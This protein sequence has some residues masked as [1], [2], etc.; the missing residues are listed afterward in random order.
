MSVKGLNRTVRAATKIAAVISIMLAPT[1]P[2]QAAGDLLVAPTRIVLDGRRGTEVILNNIGSEVATYRISLELRRMNA[3]GALDEVTV[4]EANILEKAALEMIRF[5]PRRVTLPPNQPQ[6]IRIGVTPNNTLPDGEYR[7]HMLFR[8]IPVVPAVTQDK[9]PDSVQIQ[10]I[11]IYGVTIPIIV[12]KGKLQAVAALA[13]PRLAKVE[14]GQ[15]LDFE[16]SRKGDRSV[17]GD[18]RVSKPGVATPIVVAKG[19]AIYPERDTRTVS[20]FIDETAAPQ[21]KGP[22][23]IGYYETQDAGGALIAEVKTVLN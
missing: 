5:A 2:V 18:I 16:M 17:Y 21:M 1:G 19:I 6:S 9:A 7:A 23:T 22:I 3:E 12:R 13:N 4:E 20:L 15:T 8:A 11:P 14:N 10:L